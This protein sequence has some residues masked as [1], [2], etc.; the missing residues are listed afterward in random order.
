MFES[1]IQLLHQ[2]ALNA[3][4]LVLSLL[5]GELPA[6][7]LPAEPAAVRIELR[8]DAPHA[9]DTTANCGLRDTHALHIG[10]HARDWAS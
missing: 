9:G 6:P 1:L 5:S 7:P 2:L 8:L 4:G 3:L 10:G